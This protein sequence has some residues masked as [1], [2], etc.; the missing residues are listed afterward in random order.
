MSEI[1]KNLPWNKKIEVLRIA[2]GWT[3][4]EAASRCCTSLKNYWNWE[5]GINYPRKLSQRAIASAFN[6]NAQEIFEKVGA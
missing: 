6:V 2:K 1:I 4:E 3:Q 5:K